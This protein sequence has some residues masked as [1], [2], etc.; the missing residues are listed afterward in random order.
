VLRRRRDGL[1]LLDGDWLQQIGGRGSGRL[2]KR[3]V[4]RIGAG[5]IVERKGG[6]DRNRHDVVIAWRAR[7]QRLDRAKGQ[8]RLPRR[9]R[10]ASLSE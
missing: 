3:V 4:Q 8:S 10:A 1:Q 5:V 9:Q 6:L 2:H 7:E